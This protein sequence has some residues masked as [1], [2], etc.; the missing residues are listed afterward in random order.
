MQGHDDYH[1]IQVFL[2]EGRAKAWEVVG[3]LVIE[4]FPKCFIF[5]SYFLATAFISA[6]MA[7]LWPRNF[8]RGTLSGTRAS[9]TIVLSPI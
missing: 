7:R 3:K 1:A 4:T 6:V 9:V 2:S 8:C 5:S